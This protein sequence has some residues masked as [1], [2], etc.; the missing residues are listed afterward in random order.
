[1]ISKEEIQIIAAQKK[2]STL[3]IE[4]DYVLGWLLAGI[5]HSAE[6]NN[7]WVFKGGTCLKKCYFDEYRF[8]EDLDYSYIGNRLPQS[9]HSIDFYKTLFSSI[10]KWIYEQSSIMFPE[11]GIKFEVFE[12]VRGSIS[13]QG[14]LAYRGPIQ[15]QLNIKNLPRIKI[16]LTLDEPLVLLMQRKAVFHDYSD[17]PELGIFTNCYSYEELF[18]EKL[19]ALVQRLRPRDL[20]DVVHLFQ[21]HASHQ[22][23]NT[24]K[25]TLEKKC[26][27]RS[28]SFPTMEMINQH[29]NWTYLESEWLTQLKH[30]VPILLPFDT[31]IEVMPELLKWIE[32]L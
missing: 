1:M 2:L 7:N 16:D 3:V 14:S 15:P 11:E 21:R 10:S 20:Y 28:I 22:P 17:K 30:Q 9:E 13:I 5:H 27:L 23:V 29:K 32:E 25:A 24:L 31:F 6:I 12:N 26:M 18:A 19:R 8:S 4:K